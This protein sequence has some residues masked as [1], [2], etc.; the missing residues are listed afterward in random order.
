MT[1]IDRIITKNFLKLALLTLVGFVGVAVLTQLN[2]ALV[3]YNDGTLTLYESFLFLIAEIPRTVSMMMPI[4]TLLAAVMT[5]NKMAT[6]SEIVALKT[7]GVSF[8]RIIKF[9]LI[10]A[11]ILGIGIAIMDDNYSTKGRK[12]KRE[13]KTKGDTVAW[14]RS[15]DPNYDYTKDPTVGEVI[16]SNAYIKSVKGD[17]LANIQTV[18]EKQGLI[19]NLLM[20]YPD[21]KGGLKKIIVAQHGKYDRNKQQ[22][23]GENIYH[24]DLLS[25]KE[26]FLKNGDIKELLE[27][28]SELTLNKFYMDEERISKIRENAA[29]IGATGGETRDYILEMNKR[30]ANPV[31][32]F[33]ISFFGFALGSKY[34]R[35]GAA[36]SIAFAIVLGFSTYVVKSISEAFVSGGHLSPML[37]AWLPCI[38]FA[39]ISFYTMNEAEY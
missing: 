6:N 24:K 10:A 7:S 16:S 15:E 13:L 25:N 22:W 2:R 3:R 11:L 5:I 14:K 39:G 30:I 36:V 38:I 17:Y 26:E 28:P 18:Y 4:T 34:V 8:K 23:I 19:D 33:I 12:I 29:I 37:G 20:I 9:P 35:G 31:L 21:G 27:K 1:K 32:I